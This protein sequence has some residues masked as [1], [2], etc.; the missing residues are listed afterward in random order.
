M[1]DIQTLKEIELLMQAAINALRD[2]HAHESEHLDEAHD[3]VKAAAQ[4]VAWVI[5]EV[6][7]SK[8]VYWD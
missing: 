4:R 7:E 8:K 2:T 5:R 3:N 6:E 1:T